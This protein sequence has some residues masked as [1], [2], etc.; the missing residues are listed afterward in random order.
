MI[1]DMTE[2][3]I[4]AAAKRAGD[5]KSRI[6]LSDKRTPGLRLRITPAGA[7]SWVLGM[8]DEMG[9]A[10]RFKLG[11]HPLMGVSD[12]RKAAGEM[13]V[14]VSKGADPVKAARLKRAIGRD[15]KEGIGTLGALVELYGKKQGVKRKSWQESKRRIE[16][17]FVKLLKKPM[18]TMKQGDLQ[19]EAD[20][21]PSSQ[22]AAAAV[23]YIRP[24]LKWASDG[25]RGYVSRDLADLSSPATVGKRKRFLNHDE[26]SRLLPALAA[27]EK[28]YD[29]AMR[30]I[31]L[32]ACRREEACAAKWGAVDFKAKTWTILATKNGQD[33]VV[34]LSR[35]A[36]ALLES[37]RPAN[38][39]PSNLIFG[40][41]TGARIGN[42]DRATKAIQK[43]SKTE[44]WQRHDL[45]RT[46]ARM[47][48]DMGELP[49]VIE[50]ALNHAVLLS[51][52]ATTYN[53]ARYRPEVAAALQRL[54]DAL[55]GIAAGGA[56]ILP[57][58]RKNS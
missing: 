50:A 57:M 28:P 13:R 4:T 29:R 7:K 17:V 26:L 58:K 51:D 41:N 6:E 30:F 23:R 22:S 15:A 1:V 25:G 32:T 55:D 46:A 52:I 48:G 56:Q 42:W 5:S 9:L 19:F 33:H 2:T 43:A 21:W 14:A 12:A 40:T 54:A 35:Q 27:S 37:I 24:I 45:R 31:L 11:S 39:K 8:R 38:A 10:R 20:N 47:M 36:L 3:A 34:P 16:S 44:G 18:A 53:A 49:H